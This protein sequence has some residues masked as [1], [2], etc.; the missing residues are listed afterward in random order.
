M[1]LYIEG[2]NKWGTKNMINEIV[3]KNKIKQELKKIA[4]NF[5]YKG[6]SYLVE[7]IYILYRSFHKKP[8]ECNLEDEIY[9]LVAE[10]YN[11]SANNVKCNI[12]NATDKMFYDCD[13]EVLKSYFGMYLMLKPGPKLVIR[14]VLKKLND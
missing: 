2:K 11:T 10:K 4:Y 8:E 14:T 5:S 12:R 3:V 13:E 1:Y 9:P 6:T 7:T